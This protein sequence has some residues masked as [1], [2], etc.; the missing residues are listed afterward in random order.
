MADD[1]DSTERKSIN[2][3][4]PDGDDTSY[5]SLKVPADQYDEFTRVKNDQGLTWRGLLVHAYRN[6]EAPDGLD[7][8]AGQHSKL[9]AVR[10][11]NGLTWKGM[12]LFAVRDLKEQMR[13]GE[14]HE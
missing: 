3:E 6:L 10:K 4:I 5:V 7:P 11:R 1:S 2:I 13:K 9:N 12:L 14:S 8:D